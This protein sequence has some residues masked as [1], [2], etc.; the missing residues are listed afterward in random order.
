MV[1]GDGYATHQPSGR[2]SISS[3][4]DSADTW[5]AATQGCTLQ[6]IYVSLS[7][8]AGG[9]RA[10][11]DSELLNFLLSFFYFWPLFAGIFILLV[12]RTNLY[13]Y[14][15]HPNIFF[16][17]KS[18]VWIVGSEEADRKQEERDRYD[19]QQKSCCG[20]EACAV[21]VQLPGHA[22][23]TILHKHLSYIHICS[24]DMWIL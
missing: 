4:K 3:C 13:H 17:H 21:T 5:I 2:E 16:F 8:S 6:T 10:G 19:M 15:S 14:R 1:P 9:Y 18:F 11:S 20:Y 12:L 7:H 24:C 22:V 23:M